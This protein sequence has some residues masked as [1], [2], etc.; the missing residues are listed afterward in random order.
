MARGRNSQ[1]LTTL[2]MALVGYQIEKQK[3]EDKIRQIEAQLKGRRA[4]LPS[5][6][7]AKS[8]GGRRRVLSAAARR[9][10]A[11]AQKKRWAEHRKRAAQAAKQA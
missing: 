5:D 8:G 2:Q 9:R 6:T 11:A 3:I 7:P 1:D 10:I 4:A